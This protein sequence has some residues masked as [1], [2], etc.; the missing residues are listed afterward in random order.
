MLESSFSQRTINVWNKLST[1]CV[2]ATSV[3]MFKNIIGK[4]L[5]RVTLNKSRLRRVW[6]DEYAGALTDPRLPAT[7]SNVCT[8]DAR[9]GG[10]SVGCPPP[11]QT[12]LRLPGTHLC[13]LCG[14]TEVPTSEWLPATENVDHCLRFATFA[15]DWMCVINVAPVPTS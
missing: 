7:A 2:H 3:N 12:W 10:A 11:P 13:P 15:V 1:D 6:Y 4:Y 9:L 14:D 8:T 5:G